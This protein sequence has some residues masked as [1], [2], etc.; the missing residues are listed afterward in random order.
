[1]TCG[2]A[3]RWPRFRST[4]L[5]AGLFVVAV[6]VC[7]AAAGASGA[8]SRDTRPSVVVIAPE[9]IAADPASV[10]AIERTGASIRLARSPTEQLSD[11]HLLAASAAT[12]VGVGLLRRVAVDPVRARYPGGRFVLLPASASVRDVRAAIARAAER[13][14][15]TLTSGGRRSARG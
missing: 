11:A 1:L 13:S 14:A 4:P 5:V 10:A 8:T 7:V 15:G 2:A 9:R 6:G 12:I 3:R